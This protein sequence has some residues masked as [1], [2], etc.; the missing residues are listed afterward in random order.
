[1]NSK[2]CEL[3]ICGMLVKIHFITPRLGKVNNGATN[4]SGK[5]GQSMVMAVDP[6]AIVPRKKFSAAFNNAPIDFVSTLY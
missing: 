6:I 2:K 3:E 5:G 4:S 1:M